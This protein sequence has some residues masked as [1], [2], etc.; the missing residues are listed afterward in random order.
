MQKFK[1][2]IGNVIGLGFFGLM[3]LG[4]ALLASIAIGSRPTSASEYLMVL[5]MCLLFGGMGLLCLVCAWEAMAVYLVDTEGITKRRGSS[6]QR[7]V[8]RN[9]AGFGTG[10]TP[11][12]NRL[13]LIEDTGKRLQITL[14]FLKAS[15]SQE[16]S[17]L[18]EPHL[19][20][21]RAQ[22][23]R[24]IEIAGQTFHPEWQTAGLFLALSALIFFGMA[25]WGLATPPSAENPRMGLYFCAAFFGAI[26]MGCLALCLYLLTLTRTLNSYEIV[27]RCLFYT[28]RIAFGQVQ[29][30]MTRSVSTKNGSTEVTAIQGNGR[31]IRLYASIPDYALLRDYLRAHVSLE[32]Q[33][34]GSTEVAQVQRK[35]ARQ[36]GWIG[37]VCI[38]LLLGMLGG[39]GSVAL[40]KNEARLSR[41]EQMDARGQTAPG[42]ILGTYLGS[43]GRD[44]YLILFA[45]RVNGRE[46]HSASPVT[47]EDYDS[48]RI[49]QMIWVTYLPE[50][51]QICR[52]RQSIGEQNAR[53]AI[54]A[55]YIQLGVA[56]V[57][58]LLL[59]PSYLRR[60]RKQLAKPAAK[61]SSASVLKR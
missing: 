17:A 42:H 58:I 13:T 15:D 12:T 22:R 16:L 54:R 55:V 19:A 20:P 27:E 53:L 11:T 24:E 57:A 21:L 39:M 45:F 26:G 35:E 2:A 33:E 30:L 3:A 8:W 60:I 5:P 7:L 23:M 51:P 1:G 6:V 47:Q 37:L 48:T 4:F 52:A 49:G 40:R 18:L 43:R 32:A 41:S 50:N 36:A 34:R 31:Q 61:A 44:H 29:S 14:G 38:L 9:L 59:I 28:R 10:G 46:Y 56:I 25:G